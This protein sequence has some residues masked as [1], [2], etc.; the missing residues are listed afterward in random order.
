M[1][2]GPALSTSSNL[3]CCH[4]LLF[5]GLSP[6]SGG[7]LVPFLV[8]KQFS[9]SLNSK[10][11]TEDT[12]KNQKQQDAHH[13]L[14]KLPLVMTRICT[15]H[16]CHPFK[17]MF[18]VH[19]KWWPFKN[20]I[21]AFTELLS[22]GKDEALL[23]LA[24]ERSCWNDHRG[25]MSEAYHGGKLRC[26]VHIME[27]GMCYRVNTLA[28]YIEANRVVRTNRK[29]CAKNNGTSFLIMYCP[30]LKQLVETLQWLHWIV[31]CFLYPLGSKA[32]WGP[33]NPSDC[34]G[35]RTLFGESHR[36]HKYD[37]VRG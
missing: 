16:I 37:A 11:A 28:T 20:R 27:E 30:Q 14:G 12:E 25:D 3:C 2:D 22:T 32:V 36:C 5:T 24:R 6:Q 33:S 4:M 18:G 7:E 1:I 26:Y 21:H 13:N 29:N 8:R 15:V 31:G 23:Q 9:K 17:R 34:C 19:N 10:N 35:L